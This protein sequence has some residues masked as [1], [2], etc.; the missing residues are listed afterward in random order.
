MN[1][2]PLRFTF[3]FPFFS[4]LLVC[5]A[6]NICF[7]QKG[8]IVASGPSLQ[9]FSFHGTWD[10][11]RNPARAQFGGNNKLLQGVF[12]E[13][14]S[15]MGAMPGVNEK[16]EVVFRIDTTGKV[17]TVR[18]IK[19]FESVKLSLAVLQAIQYTSGKWRPGIIDGKKVEEEITA[20]FQFYFDWNKQTLDGL[21][22]KAQQRFDDGDYARALKS[23]DEILKYDTYNVKASV[24]KGKCHIKLNELS[25]ACSLWNAR[26]KFG[27]PEIEI[28]ILENCK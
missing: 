12:N 14:F 17:D 24:L 6:A 26:R 5:I 21:Q 11:A 9:V 2:A 19:R 13:Y 16:A 23:L 22:G 27:Y 1:T 3:L 15:K 10:K 18:F 7:A 20:N 28:L 8:E 4:I 25:D